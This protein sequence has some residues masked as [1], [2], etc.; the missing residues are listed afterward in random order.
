MVT[1]EAELLGTGGSLAANH[2]ALGDADVL[3]AHADNLS[4]F[5][6][7]A[8]IGAFSARPAASL[9]TMMTF[10]TDA[11]QTCG[12]VELDTQGMVQAFHEKVA[13]PPS[14]LANG[15]VYLLSPAARA[16]IASLGPVFEFS[17]QVIPAFV[18]KIYCWQNTVYHR[19]V[20]NPQAYLAA[21]TEF[22]PIA[23]QFELITA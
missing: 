16:R 23:E 3:L 20:G 6:P 1:H 21:Q 13:N 9:L 5:D 14:N 11:P 2:E 12:I 18:G 8:F 22:R 10:E 19:D 17:T 7:R 15:A 4:A